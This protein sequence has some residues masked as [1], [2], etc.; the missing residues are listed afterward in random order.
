MTP[1]LPRT[2][3]LGIRLLLKRP[4]AAAI[5]ITNRCNLRCRHCYW[6]EQEHP[7]QLG[8]DEMLALLHRLRGQGIR[9]AI[10][11]GGEPAL[12]MEVCKAAA[13][14]F[15]S[16]LIFTNGTFELEDLGVRGQWIVS[17]DGPQEVNDAIRGTGTF[18]QATEHISRA[19][20]PPIVHITISRLNEQF[21]ER[22][23]QEM[24]EFPIKGIG[25]S[26]FTPIRGQHQDELLIPVEERKPIVERLLALRCRYGERVGFT[27]AIARQ[28]LADGA[29]K[30]WNSYQKCPVSKAV[31]CYRSDGSTKGCTYGDDADCT[32]CGCAAVTAFR[33]AFYPP[34]YQTMRLVLGLLWPPFSPRIGREHNSG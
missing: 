11:Y 10:L 22:F 26:F 14:I 21:V 13:R 6:W 34:N 31:R 16:V 28:L 27:P 8:H 33:G 20:R 15:D 9:A 19:P 23:V 4:A 1:D 24:L 25:F 7:R 12:R 2:L 29:F 17:L 5:D 32:R 18:K 3:A 30:A